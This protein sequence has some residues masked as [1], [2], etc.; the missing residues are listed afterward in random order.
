MDKKMFEIFIYVIFVI[1]I[2][3]MM[4][5]YNCQEKFDD[6]PPLPGGSWR[7]S[8]KKDS[9]SWEQNNDST[10]TLTTECKNK[11]GKYI[12][13]SINLKKYAVNLTNNDGKLQTI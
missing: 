3:F 5:K 12:N 11:S 9:A 8:C 10:Y 2:Y 1:I 7:K 13:T 4:Q 6:M